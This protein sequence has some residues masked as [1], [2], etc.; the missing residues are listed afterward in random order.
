M[1]HGKELGSSGKWKF[2]SKLGLGDPLD[3]VKHF[4]LSKYLS[5]LL[6]KK[7]ESSS[8]YLWNKTKGIKD[9]K[10]TIAH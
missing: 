6:V 5:Y 3:C 7:N 4:S 8:S 10:E 1:P 9:H 2:W